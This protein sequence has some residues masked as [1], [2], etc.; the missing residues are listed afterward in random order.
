MS[1]LATIHVLV[2]TPSAPIVRYWPENG[3]EDAVVYEWTGDFW[4]V[5]LPDG[6]M[7]IADSFDQ[8]AVVG[9]R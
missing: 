1:H 3:Y 4:R 7:L 8:V 2:G 5:Y 9:I 6:S